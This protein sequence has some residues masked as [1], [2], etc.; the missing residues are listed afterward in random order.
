M[1]F[2][3]NFDFIYIFIYNNVVLL[4]KTIQKAIFS[5]TRK[6][7]IVINRFYVRVKKKPKNGTNDNTI[8]VCAYKIRLLN[9]I[10][11]YI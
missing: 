1:Q 2:L 8:V 4:I 3:K 6:K 11:Y 5:R 10:S 9:V 7:S